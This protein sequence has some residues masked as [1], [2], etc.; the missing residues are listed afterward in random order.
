MWH[1]V[2]KNYSVDTFR[3][4]GAVDLQ[5][6]TRAKRFRSSPGK[7]HQVI[8]NRGVKGKQNRSLGPYVRFWLRNR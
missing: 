6:G 8:K 7:K 1:M 4:V 3:E 5:S 2:H